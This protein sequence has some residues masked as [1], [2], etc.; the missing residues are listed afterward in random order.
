LGF[1][2]V[3]LH[4]AMEAASGHSGT[5]NAVAA[6]GALEFFAFGVPLQHAVSKSTPCTE[7]DD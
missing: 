7:E 3:N 2:S 5:A 4:K 1:F 6:P